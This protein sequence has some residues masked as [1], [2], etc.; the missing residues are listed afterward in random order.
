M[1]SALLMRRII[2]RKPQILIKIKE[3]LIACQHTSLLQSGEY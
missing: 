3:D 2:Y 1:L